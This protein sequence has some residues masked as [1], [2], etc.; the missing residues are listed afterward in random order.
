MTHRADDRADVARVDRHL[1]A[2]PAA[3]VRRD[4]PDL[5]LGQAGDQRVQRAVRVRC[6]GGAPDRELPGHRVHVGH[7][8]AGLQRGRV[9]PRVHHVLGDHHVRGGEHR[10]GGRLVAR[11]PVEDVV[12]RRPARSSRITG[13]PGSSAGRVDHDRERLV[14]DVDQL[15]RIPGR[16]PV[17]GHH[18]R[19]LLALEPDLVGGQHGLHVAGQSRHPGQFPLVQHVPGDDGLDLGVRLRRPWCRPRRSG[20]ARS[21]LRRIAP[22]SIPGSAMSSTNVPMPRMNRAS[23]LRRTGPYAPFIGGHRVIPTTAAARAG[24]L[25]FG[26]PPHGPDDV[27][28]AGAPAQLA[29]DR[30]PDLVGRRVRVVVEQPAGGQHHAR[31]AEPA[32]QAVAL[33]EALLHRVQLGPVGQ[34]LHGA[35]PAAVGHRRQ[36]RARLDRRLVQ[37]HHAGPAVGGVAAPVRA[38][39]PQLVAQEVDQ[40]QPGFDLAGVAGAVD[41]HGDLHVRRRPGPAAPRGAARGW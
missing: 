12:V 26:G 29:G 4:D 1:V 41:R 2:E 23:S 14:L 11:G 33:G 10:V 35:H 32:L 25:V 36:H 39:Q 16:V 40:Q 17:L 19:H 6:L 18:E 34:T 15:E 20:R 28:V 13:A 38:G 3:D 24:S 21:G 7:G 5:V 27:L 31:R 30:L 8:A 9:R 22:C 37:P